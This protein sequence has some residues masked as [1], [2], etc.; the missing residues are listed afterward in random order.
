MELA[1]GALEEARSSL[2]DQFNEDTLNDY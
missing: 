1:F 2:L